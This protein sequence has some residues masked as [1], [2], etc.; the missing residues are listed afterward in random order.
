MVNVQEFSTRHIR[1]AHSI[2]GQP[3][4]RRVVIVLSAGPNG[5]IETPSEQPFQTFQI[6]GDDIA[7]RVQ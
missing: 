5:Q 3:L 1:E 7:Y 6:F 2:P 4:P